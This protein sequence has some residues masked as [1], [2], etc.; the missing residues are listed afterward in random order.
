MEIHELEARA[1]KLTKQLEA[2][3]GTDDAATISA[4]LIRVREAIAVTRELRGASLP[5]GHPCG[6]SAIA[7]RRNR[8]LETEDTAQFKFEGERRLATVD[9]A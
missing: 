3:L 9:Q 5:S 6:A 4:D 8:E 1:A 2:A 7:E